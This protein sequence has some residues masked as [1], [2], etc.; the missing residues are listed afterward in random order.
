MEIPADDS[1]RAMEDMQRSLYA[2]AESI[3]KRHR[4][5]KAKLLRDFERNA[6]ANAK[7]MVDRLDRQEDALRSG[8]ASLDGSE[9][10]RDIFES[11][12]HEFD[13]DIYRMLRIIAGYENNISDSFVQT[14]QSDGDTIRDHLASHRASPDL[15]TMPD[16]RTEDACLSPVTDGQRRPVSL[17]RMLR[18]LSMLAC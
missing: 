15:G 3:Q 17:G 13:S 10:Y 5:T 7:D 6:Q 12:S 2:A 8:Y 11:A 16:S 1:T 14:P 18:L 4:E 9:R